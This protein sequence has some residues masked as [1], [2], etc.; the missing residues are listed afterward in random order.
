[1]VSEISRA[2]AAVAVLVLLLVPDVSGQVQETNDQEARVSVPDITLEEGTYRIEITLEQGRTVG[3]EIR[4]LPSQAP[5]S[6]PSEIPSP[7]PEPVLPDPEPVPPDP[8]PLPWYRSIWVP[9]IAI[10]LMTVLANLAILYYF[11]VVVPRRELD[12]YWQALE[13]IRDGRYGEA[14]PKLT[15]VEAKLPGGVRQDARFFIALCHF[16]CDNEAEAEHILDNLH[17]ESPKNPNVAYFLAY[18]HVRNGN[19]DDAQKVLERMDHNHQL[20]VRDAR[21]LLAIVWFRRGLHAFEAGEIDLAAD[22]FTKVEQQGEY[23]EHIPSDLRNRHVVLG[24]K[25]LFAR[26]LDEAR[27]EFRNLKKAASKLDGDEATDLKAKASVG[28]TLVA[29]LKNNPSKYDKLEKLMAKT[30]RLLH[31][32]GPL[33]LPWPEPEDGRARGDA[34]ALK[35]ALEEADRNVDL[36]EELRA[37]RIGLRDIHFLRGMA[38]LRAWERLDGEKAHAAIAENLDA[39]RSRLACARA[40]DE[41]FSDVYLVIGLLMFYL[42]PPGP[43]RTTAVDLLEDARRLGMR[44]PDA[45]EIVNDRE[46]IEKENADAVDKYQQVLD[47]FLRDETVRKEV[48]QALLQRLSTLRSLMN[49]YKPPD[50]TRA[51]TVP[52][53]IQELSM[54]S[55]SLRARIREL[56][57]GSRSDELTI[58][59]DDLEHQTDK[60]TQQAQ[61]LEKTEAELLAKTGDELFKDA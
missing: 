18:I 6:V 15:Q 55:A 19:D 43:E 8:T 38:V 20:D 9:I 1:M 34:E 31:P 33:E 61:V 32:D 51:R 36:P 11:K 42:H 23:A 39:V 21:R 53:T 48:R 49:R 14:L 46:R 45:M 52:P 58:L 4:I 59:G 22:L 44:D 7:N 3:G 30:C 12:P 10:V 54:R 60:L 24:T 16:R 17:R 35:R 41:R 27:E 40:L 47:L 37:A 25:A 29:W 5:G 13:L 2:A 56:R 50:L 28:L 26:Q 57:R